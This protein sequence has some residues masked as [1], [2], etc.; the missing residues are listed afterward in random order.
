MEPSL[1]PRS[2]INPDLKTTAE[3][4]AAYGVVRFGSIDELLDSPLAEQVDGILIASVHASHY[5]IGMK[6]IQRGWH[7]L[8]EKPMT[9][10]PAEVL[11]PHPHPHPHHPA[12][13]STLCRT[14]PAQSK[15]KG[16][17]MRGLRG[18]VNSGRK[19][20]FG[21]TFAFSLDLFFIAS[22]FL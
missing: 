17:E 11:H 3:L 10:D 2:T 13:T 20:S 16:R 14:G 18:L 7:I 4:E 5:D 1:A 21:S 6:A 9:T 8:M 22:I 19:S 15:A 12:P